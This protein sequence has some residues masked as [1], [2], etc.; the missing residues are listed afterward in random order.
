MSDAPAKKPLIP[1]ITGV[2]ALDTAIAAGILATAGIID[3]KIYGLME[4]HALKPDDY[5]SA[6]FS[7]TLATLVAIATFGWRLFQTKLNQLSVAQHVITSQ[8][9]GIIPDNVQAAAVKAPS[10]SEVE[11]TKA[12]NNA[13]ATK[14]S[15]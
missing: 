1:S 7:A 4:A 11:I 15:Q 2:P 12:L 10:I 3:G 14:A 8:A 5:K 6:I 13:E 9:T